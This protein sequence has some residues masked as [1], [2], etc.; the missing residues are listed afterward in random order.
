MNR[1]CVARRLGAIDG[2]AASDF[3]FAFAVIFMAATDF[4]RTVALG[5]PLPR[6]R[7]LVT[8]FFAGLASLLVSRW[9]N[10]SGYA[11]ARSHPSLNRNK[12][13]S[14]LNR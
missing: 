10:C 8:E 3:F 2:V 1:L 12:T 9:R 7:F 13:P 4:F 5:L 14:F 11:S 6:L